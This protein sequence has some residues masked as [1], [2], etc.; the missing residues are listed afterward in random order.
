[1]LPPKVPARLHVLL[2]S[3]VPLAVV[4]RR[5]PSMQVCTILW[6][7]KHDTFQ[8]GQWLKGRI[9]ERCS[10]LSPD[11]KSLITYVTKGRKQD[12][13]YNWLAISEAPYL[14]A[15]VL[16]EGIGVSFR[17]AIWQGN[18][19]YWA[20]RFFLG[21]DL[22]TH[23]KFTRVET[24]RWSLGPPGSF[25]STYFAR[26]FR[27]GWLFQSVTVNNEANHLYHFTKPIHQS[28]KLHKSYNDRRSG[29]T[30]ENYSLH[31]LESNKT[32]DFPAWE[33]ADWV[34]NRLVWATEGRL[35]TGTL[36]TTG[37]TDIRVL[38]EFN[39][40]NFEQILAPY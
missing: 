12:V 39:D 16:S 28:W 20:D 18:T 22:T 26:H 37:I 8:M 2:A 19:R 23:P 32:F 7:R 1:M 17:G 25:F 5:G 4:L 24:C 27:D 3:K 6:N 14:K 30:E 10:D 9:Y 34:D 31:R 11:G 35:E 21:D 13:G 38:K 15:H 40:M 36:T 29:K 33:W